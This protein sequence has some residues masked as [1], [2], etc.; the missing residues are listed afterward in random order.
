VDAA[1]VQEVLQMAWGRRQPAARVIHQSNRGSQYA[2]GT[3][4]ALLA[5]SG[6]RC[7]MSRKGDGLDNAVAERVFGRLKGECTRSVMIPPTRR[8]GMR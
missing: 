2:C 8:R 1:L 5:A 6:M 4:Q 3:Y 7:R